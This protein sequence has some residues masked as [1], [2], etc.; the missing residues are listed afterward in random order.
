MHRSKTE[1]PKARLP[2]P[3]SHPP[4]IVTLPLPAKSQN[5]FISLS[6]CCTSVVSAAVAAAA[7]CC[8][9]C[10]CYCSFKNQ[11][12]VAAVPRRSRPAASVA[13]S[14]AFALYAFVLKVKFAPHMCLIDI[15]QLQCWSPVDRKK[16]CIAN[17]LMMAW[18][19]QKKREEKCGLKQGLPI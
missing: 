3:A 16:K 18:L 19:S 12:K 2:V 15:G 13:G 7:A 11:V 9:C 1:K 10:C 6:Q 14:A 4:A 8:C 5:L 17:R